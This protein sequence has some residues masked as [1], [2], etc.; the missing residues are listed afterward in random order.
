MLF[1][2]S[3]IEGHLGCF[4]FL[5]LMN[6][7]VMNIHVNVFMWRYGFS[8]LGYTAQHGIVLAYGNAVFSIFR[9]CPILP[10]HQQIRRVLVS[11]HPLTSPW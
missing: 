5:A 3:S 11:L 10:C 1:I 8:S 9:N 4:C 2:G 7:V 6:N